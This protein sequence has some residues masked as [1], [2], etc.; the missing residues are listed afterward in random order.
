MMAYLT[1]WQKIIKIFKLIRK[2][3]GLIIGFA[4]L[5]PFLFKSLYMNGMLSFNGVMNDSSLGDYNWSISF[6]I[7][8][9]ML[10]ILFLPLS[11]LLLKQWHKPTLYVLFG[12]IVMNVSQDLTVYILIKMYE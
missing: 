12:I 6:D 4:V 8:A 1:M 10:L 3:A 9:F 2:W 7:V 5:I 11:R